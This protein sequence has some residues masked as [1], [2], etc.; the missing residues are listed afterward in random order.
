MYTFIISLFIDYV[1]F[2]TELLA[3]QFHTLYHSRVIKQM[4]F[5]FRNHDFKTFVAR[6]IY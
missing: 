6:T 4:L 1:I 2:V 5:I 3:Q